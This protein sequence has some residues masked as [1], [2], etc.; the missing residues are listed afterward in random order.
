MSV[1]IVN[2]HMPTVTPAHGVRGQSWRGLFGATSA[3]CVTLL[4]RY[5]YVGVT[6]V[7][8][9]YLQ[10]DGLNTSLRSYCLRVR[11]YVSVG[12][13]VGCVVYY[14]VSLCVYIGTG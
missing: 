4:R 11:P 8:M 1:P 10:G 9:C 7:F 2:R 6:A 12:W 5:M 3:L 14:G 13:L